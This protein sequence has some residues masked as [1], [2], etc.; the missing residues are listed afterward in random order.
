MS[1]DIF[2]RLIPL[3]GS[4]LVSSSTTGVPDS[5]TDAATISGVEVI[6]ASGKDDAT[7]GS[8]VTGT[9]GELGAT[10]SS[11]AKSV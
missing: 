2:V 6:A 5:A 11:V 10:V 9:I 3:T 1:D 8:W 4:L 7:V